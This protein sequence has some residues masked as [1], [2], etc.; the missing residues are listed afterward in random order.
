MVISRFGSS[1]EDRRLILHSYFLSELK[2][3]DAHGAVLVPDGFLGSI[4]GGQRVGQVG[5]S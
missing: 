2:I 3:Q 1:S 5:R 4:K